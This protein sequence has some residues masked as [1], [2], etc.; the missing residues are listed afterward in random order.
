MQHNC[1]EEDPK[2]N[3]SLSEE[4]EE[5]ELSEHEEIDNNLEDPL[6]FRRRHSPSS[7]ELH[8]FQSTQRPRGSCQIRPKP[9]YTTD[10]IICKFFREGSVKMAK[11]VLRQFGSSICIKAKIKI[12]N[13]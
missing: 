12:S 1:Q 8:K 10:R 4:P 11:E 13:D 9:R 3:I 6:L 2:R 7:E 5:G